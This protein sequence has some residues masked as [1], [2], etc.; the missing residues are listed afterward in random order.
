MRGYQVRSVLQRQE[1]E[2]GLMELRLGFAWQAKMMVL[3]VLS[4]GPLM[5]LARV[6]RLLLIWSQQQ[7]LQDLRGSCAMKDQV[8]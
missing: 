2:L 7:N 5:V 1:P 4:S 8:L 3:G 6:G